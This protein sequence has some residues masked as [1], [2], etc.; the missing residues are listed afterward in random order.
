MLSAVPEFPD[1]VTQMALELWGRRDEPVRAIQRRIEKERRRSQLTEASR[2]KNLGKN[3][4]LNI[5]VGSPSE[6]SPMRPLAA[7]GPLRSVP[8]GFRLAVMDTRGL[9]GLIS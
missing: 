9:N 1:G 5:P 2:E 7:D 8:S 3:P 4:F 6:E